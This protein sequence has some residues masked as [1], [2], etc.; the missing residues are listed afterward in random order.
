MILTAVT[1]RNQQ[2]FNRWLAKYQYQGT[3]L[4]EQ[5]FSRP[6]LTHKEGEGFVRI[7]GVLGME[8]GETI[9]AADLDCE[10]PTTIQIVVTGNEGRCDGE[11]MRQLERDY[12]LHTNEEGCCVL[13]RVSGRTVGITGPVANKAMFVIA[14][15][16]K[17]LKRRINGE[18]REVIG[19]FMPC[20]CRG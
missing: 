18:L 6:K 7:D 3:E 5:P 4:W 17:P 10:S 16:G 1:F 15:D 2:Q 8:D 11:K 20:I 19:R 14:R 13:C 12:P 9:T